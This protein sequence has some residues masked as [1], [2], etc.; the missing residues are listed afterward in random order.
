MLDIACGP[1]GW[2][3]D[4]AFARPDMEVIGIDISQTMITYAT[5]SANSQDLRNISFDVMDT[6]QRLDFP[7][8]SFDLVN[9]RLLSSFLRK[10]AWVGL[11][12]ECKRILRPG[13]VLRITETDNGGITAA[14]F[15]PVKYSPI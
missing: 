14:G 15:R 13:G 11:F 4:L 6:T 2:A 5:A 10:D 9:G 12:Q 7:D 3:L 1:G 8:H